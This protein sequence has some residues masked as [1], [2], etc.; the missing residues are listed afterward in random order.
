MVR[1]WM[2]GPDL[3]WSWGAIQGGDHGVGLWAGGWSAPPSNGVGGQ[4]GASSLQE[5]P[6][7]VGQ[8]V[9]PLIGVGGQIQ[10]GVGWREGPKANQGGGSSLGV[11]LAGV[12]GWSRPLL[13][14]GS[15]QG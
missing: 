14:W 10:G 4:L 9:L 1:G 13:G 12:K 5:G 6:W 7:M 11:G 2:A 8:S 3:E 15:D